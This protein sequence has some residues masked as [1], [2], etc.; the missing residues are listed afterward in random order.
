MKYPMNLDFRSSIG[1]ETAASVGRLWTVGVT[2]FDKT[3]WRDFFVGLSELGPSSALFRF[4]INAFSAV[5]EDLD[6]FARVVCKKSASV[7]R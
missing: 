6:L 4:S 3:V 5:A 1:A 7:L 2:L